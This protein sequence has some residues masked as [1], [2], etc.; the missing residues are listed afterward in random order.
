MELNF[1]GVK[2]Q[3]WIIPT[4]RVQTVDGRKW[5]HL[6]SYHVYL[7]KLWSLKCQKWT[8]FCIFCWCQQ[9]ISHS[10]DKILMRIRKILLSSLRKR[11]GLLDSELP[12]ARYQH[13][14]IQSFVIFLLTQQVF[15]STWYLTKGNSKTFEPYHFL[16]DLKNIF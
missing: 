5:G 11:Y 14:K 16:K 15:F 3:K 8:S 9:K 12:L 13:F 4:D 2:M 10:L 1:E 6:S 7:P